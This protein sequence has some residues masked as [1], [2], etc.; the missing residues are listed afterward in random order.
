M[1]TTARGLAVS[2]DSPDAIRALDLFTDRLAGIRLGVE[3]VLDDIERH[4]QVASLQLA[5]AMLHLY[6]Q[7]ADAT[8]TAARYLDAVHALEPALNERELATLAALDRWLQLDVLAA[9]EVLEAIVATWPRDL[10]ALK[11][12]EFLYY[13]LGQ[14][15]MGPRFLATVEPVAAAN[16]D[17]A[18]VLAVWAFATELSGFPDRAADLAESALTIDPHTPWAH[19]AL[20]HAFITRG[21]PPA[22]RD[23]LESF[24]PVWLDSGRVIHA[25]NA[26]HLAVAH[27]DGL[28]VDR[29]DLVYREHVWGFL[30][31]TPGEQIDAISYLWRREMAGI[32]V[33]DAVWLDVADHVQARV[34]ECV[35]P[36]L[37]A[38]HGY[39]LARA[40]RLD[41]L[42]TLRAT[43][44]RRTG[45]D[46]AEARR[47][48]QPV[49]RRVVEA[50][51]AHGL[52][53]LAG[54]AAGLDPVM[55]QM[56]AVG[57]SD[58]QDDLFRLAYLTALA[59][60]GRSD[61]ARRWW[62]A[63]TAFKTPSPLDEQLLAAC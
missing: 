39:A 5:G 19:H 57:G 48:W 26:W 24:L 30:P 53:D 25:H 14:Q 9:A 60:A 54:A 45:R 22:A 8:A 43:V 4:P 40:G 17:D 13:V 59:G 63:M 34:D 56:T 1:G 3:A 12:L 36:F 35:F 15:H 58:A 32:P 11:A 44:D 7:T 28:A 49:G 46:D 51:I 23:R 62:T 20:A 33:D 37:S 21:D 29:A 31:D 6:G 41:A 16:P 55:D 2:T 61:D 50:C 52:G 10:L 18:D 27:L 47:V 38:H 42:A